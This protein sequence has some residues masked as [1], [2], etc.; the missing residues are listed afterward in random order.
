MLSAVFDQDGE[1]IL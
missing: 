1:K